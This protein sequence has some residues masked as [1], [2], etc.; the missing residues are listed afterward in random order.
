MIFKPWNKDTIFSESPLRI[1]EPQNGRTFDISE[2][3]LCLLPMV[4]YHKSGT[5]I[6]YGG[7][8]YDRYFAHRNNLK[9][10]LAGVAYDFQ[11]FEMDMIENWDVPMDYIFTN[12]E[13]IEIKKL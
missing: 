12:N 10:I 6:G 11:R 2:I 7:G 4:G 9:P 1:N 3:D 5:R 8:F 13:I